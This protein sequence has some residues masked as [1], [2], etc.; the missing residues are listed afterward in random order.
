MAY[1]DYWV[2]DHT[3]DALI[4]ARGGRAEGDST[5]SRAKMVIDHNGI[6]HAF[7]IRK[8][9]ASLSLLGY[10]LRATDHSETVAEAVKVWV[11]DVVATS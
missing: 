2:A 3:R 11:E 1:K 9:L 5:S 10:Y 7:C 8:C 4:S 6:G